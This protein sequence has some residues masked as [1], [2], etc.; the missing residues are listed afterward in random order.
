MNILASIGAPME[1]RASPNVRW[2]AIMNP[3]TSLSLGC[4]V[5]VPRIIV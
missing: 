4:F 3:A 1:P 2:N 5:F